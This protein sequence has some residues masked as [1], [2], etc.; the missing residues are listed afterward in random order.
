LNRLRGRI[1]FGFNSDGADPHLANT[2]SR[3]GGEIHGTTARKQATSLIITFACG[4]KGVAVLLLISCHSGSAQESRPGTAPRS[5]NNGQGL[6]CG[7]SL[8]R[9]TQLG[10]TEGCE[11]LSRGWHQ[12]RLVTRSAG[13]RRQRLHS[14]CWAESSLPPV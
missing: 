4:H 12:H 11:N 3:R 13:S 1:Y 10:W 14:P 7:P 6:Q 9:R 2:W 5:E 8:V